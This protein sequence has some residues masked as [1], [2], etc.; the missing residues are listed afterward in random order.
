[1]AADPKNTRPTGFG[2]LLR[3][4]R[5]HAPSDQNRRVTQQQLAER[6]GRD[7]TTLS[8]WETEERLPTQE[9][10]E[11]LAQA[12]GLSQWQQDRLRETA[13]YPVADVATLHSQL[14]DVS[15]VVRVMRDQ[16]RV[17]QKLP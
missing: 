2:E 11:K 16:A 17:F 14:T 7:P 8:R 1:M 5:E 13:G 15:K 9:D 6:I 12:L 3:S 10:I 4:F